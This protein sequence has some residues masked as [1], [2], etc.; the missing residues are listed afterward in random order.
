MR[1]LF[2]ARCFLFRFPAE[3]TK[4]RNGE[5]FASSSSMPMPNCSSRGPTAL[6][7]ENLSVRVWY[8]F[9]LRPFADRKNT[10]AGPLSRGDQV[11]GKGDLEL[12]E[13]TRLYCWPVG[14]LGNTAPAVWLFPYDDT[15]P[16]PTTVAR[17]EL[18]IAVVFETRMIELDVFA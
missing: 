14:A 12:T 17:F 1:P 11:G 16:P 9:R 2:A 10:L 6:S 13:L 3:I 5:T 18:P 8:R 7:G 4:D 15:A